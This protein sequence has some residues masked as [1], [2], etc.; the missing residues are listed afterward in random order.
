MSEPIKE[1]DIEANVEET[2]ASVKRDSS[3]DLG[4]LIKK[5]PEKKEEKHEVESPID[6]AMKHQEKGLI[7]DKDEMTNG[8]PELRANYDTDESRKGFDEKVNE[9]SEDAKKAQAVIAIKKPENEIETVEMMDELSNITLDDNGK[10]IVPEGSKYFVAKDNVD[11][12]PEKVNEE[13][14]SAVATD[15]SLED[16][17]EKKKIV[18]I[19]IDKTGLGANIELDENEKKVVDESTEIRL[20]EVED[21]ELKTATVVRDNDDDLSFMESVEKYQLSVSKTSM[22]FPLSGF[23]ADMSGLSYGEF[24]D[25]T[26]DVSDESSDE[27]DFDK[28]WKMLS[29]VYEKM[30]NISSG[31]FKNFEDFLKKFAWKDLPL[32]IYALLI[33]TQPET[34]TLSMRCNEPKCKKAFTHKYSTR[35]L[36]DFSSSEKP[37]LQL[38]DKVANAKGHDRFK[39]AE[40]SLVRNIKKIALPSRMYV[41][42]IGPAS[43]WDYL[44]G[45][46]EAFSEFQSL[47]EEEREAQ[48]DEFLKQ[49]YY[50]MMLYI[51]RAIDVKD[52]NGVWHRITNYKKIFE[53][54]DKHMTPADFNVV[55]AITSKSEEDYKIRFTL[56]NI[57]CP[58]CGAVTPS[59][60]IE[61]KELV[62]QIQQTMS[63]TQI[64]LKDF[65]LF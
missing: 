26:L 44:Y 51:I 41:L 18:Q 23:S 62:F 4:T 63:N 36:I 43:C 56:K 32:A 33:S 40:E 8:E 11:K 25:I 24:A 6:R 39:V 31:P 49:V 27:Y 5:V 16:D 54:F 45:I 9:L 34:D 28:N 52:E 55:R 30:K 58:H 53:I 42:E 46:C 60:D 65:Q 64:T 14:S 19:L 1:N 61:P 29:V 12:I 10:A 50:S 21:K 20:V 35:S 7:V 3:M 2:G 57:V 48:S 59:I 13:N 22:I 38:I 17:E 47:S 37:Y 15:T